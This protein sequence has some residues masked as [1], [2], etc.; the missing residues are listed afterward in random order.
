MQDTRFAELTG[1]LPRYLG[2]TDGG[3]FLFL[4]RT[5]FVPR[6]RA[7]TGLVQQWSRLI[8]FDSS[9]RQVSDVDSIVL[10]EGFAHGVGFQRVT[11]GFPFAGAGDAV[12]A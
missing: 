7:R 9:S 3:Q 1:W 12:V 11:C 2:Q 6:A 5:A 8:V 4:D 10:S